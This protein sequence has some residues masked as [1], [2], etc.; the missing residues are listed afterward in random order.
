LS[1][2]FSTARNSRE[3]A[4]VVAL[5]LGV[6]LYP[7]AAKMNSGLDILVSGLAAGTI[8]YGVHWWREVRT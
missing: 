6:L 4:D 1:F 7:L 8:A 5:A 2:L 3:V